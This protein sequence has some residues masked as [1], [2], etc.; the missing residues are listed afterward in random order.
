MKF[1]YNFSDIT[2]EGLGYAGGK[3]SSL[4]RMYNAGIAVPNGFVILSEAFENNELKKAAHLDIE[5]CLERMSESTFAV[6]SSALSEDS[7]KTSFAGEFESVLYVPR[8]DVFSA[9]EKVAASAKSERV[10]Q[11]SKV[12]GINDEHKIAVVVQSMINAKIAGVLFSADPITGSHVNM[13]GNFVFGAGEQ[14]VSGEKNAHAFTISRIGGKY[15]GNKDLAANVKA[16]YKA[17]LKAEE[18]FGCMLDIEWV[19]EGGKLYIVQARPITTLQTIDYDTYEI[20]QSLDTDAL[21]SSNN[22]GEAVP[23]VMSPFTWSLLHEMDLECQKVPGYFMFGNICGRTYSNISVM[24]S[25]LRVLGYNVEKAKELISD[26]FGNIPENIEV[27]IYPFGKAY[28]IREMFKRS[29]KSIK[30]MRDSK[31]QKIYYL[32]NTPVW[33]VET[34]KRIEDANTRE[35]LL[36]L[37]KSDLRPYLSALW[38]IWFGGAGSATLVTLRKKFEKMAGEELANLLCSNF[39]GEQSLVSMKPL[40]AIEQVI[41]GSLTPEKYLE[42]YGHRSPH[43]FEV[44]YEYPA[45]DPSFIEKQVEEFKNTNL[46]ATELMKKQQSEFIKGKDLFLKRFPGKQQWLEKKLEKVSKDAHTRESLRNEF[47]KVFR[48]IRHLLLKIG[49][50]TGIGEDIFMMY[51]FE[52]PKFLQGDNEML[53]KLSLRRKNF[54][55]YQKLP[56][57]PQLIRGRFNP[58]EWINSKDRR[59]DYY[60]PNAEAPVK[61]ENVI[62][63]FAGAPGTVEGR[64]RVL[65]SFEEAEAFEKGEILVTTMTNIGWTPLFPKATAIITDLGAP[66][67]HAA[68]VARELGI[69]A[70]VGCGIATTELKT[71]DYV[72]VN[73]SSGVVKKRS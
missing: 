73:G 65:H 70:V 19:L 18:I 9:I 71:G 4:C 55:E 34:L 23:D 26:V 39:S 48:V 44:Y 10:S 58:K 16:L 27:P 72:I 63:G 13:V 36:E 35:E 41:S 11:Y 2:N 46:R 68:I 50:V 14:L 49:S 12:H 56:V 32:K 22:V 15:N 60:D 1:A 61:D 7:A 20:N 64:V 40:L 3:G 67:S 45:D 69:P 47:V 21:W 5:K 38:N 24:I 17:A 29:K 31:K 42:L 53:V 6:R 37:W 8:T 57:F 25:S 59:Q 66:L 51:C 28:L 62:K 30:R 33:Y 43:E 52:V 54:E